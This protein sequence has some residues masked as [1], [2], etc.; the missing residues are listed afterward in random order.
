MEFDPESHQAKLERIC[1]SHRVLR[2]SLFGS[3]A[4]GG[5]DPARSDLD[6]AVEFYEMPPIEHKRAYFGLLRDLESLSGREVD[7]IE[8]RAVSNPYLL[9]D[10]ESSRA[11]VYEAA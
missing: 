9:R 3:A 5:F 10:I 4:S 1:V 8:T 6:F 2:L 7:L 11:V